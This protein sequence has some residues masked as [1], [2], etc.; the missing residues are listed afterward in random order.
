MEEA[1]FASLLRDLHMLQNDRNLPVNTGPQAQSLARLMR[2]HVHASGD[3]A[4]MTFERTLQEILMQTLLYVHHMACLTTANGGAHPVFLSAT[5]VVHH[6]HLAAETQ[7]DWMAHLRAD[8]RNA[9]EARAVCD[10]VVAACRLGLFACLVLPG[11][12]SPDSFPQVTLHQGLRERLVSWSQNE[13]RWMA[14]YQLLRLVMGRAQVAAHR[15]DILDGYP[16]TGDSFFCGPADTTPDA[17]CT[18]GGLVPRS[19]LAPEAA[20]APDVVALR[21]ALRTRCATNA[22]VHRHVREF[23]HHA[24][25]TR[26]DH[27]AALQLWSACRSQR[28]VKKQR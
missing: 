5:V 13:G 27:I 23:L 11:S 15:C 24:G 28:G 3:G 26:A 8:K 17:G 10:A 1:E 18:V 7:R 16:P 14:L 22:D 20:E 12:N 21:V 6:R 4:T 2:H 25:Y 19:W 9:S